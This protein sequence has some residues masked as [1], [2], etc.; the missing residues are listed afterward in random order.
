[1]DVNIL[2]INLFVLI[3][4]FLTIFTYYVD[5]ELYVWHLTPFCTVSNK[6]IYI[7]IDKYICKYI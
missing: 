1:M 6:V 7:I 2:F 5:P 4:F 3:A